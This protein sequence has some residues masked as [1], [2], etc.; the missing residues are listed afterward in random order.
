MTDI[1]TRVQSLVNNMQY[2]NNNGLA[3]GRIAR[4]LLSAISEEAH[5]TA[6]PLVSDVLARI[7]ERAE[8]KLS[9]LK[10][11]PGPC[12]TPVRPVVHAGTIGTD[13]GRHTPGS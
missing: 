1:E 13:A 4:E 12:Q 8:V 3:S 11:A 2:I 9:E 5:Q 10:T 6:N 7:V